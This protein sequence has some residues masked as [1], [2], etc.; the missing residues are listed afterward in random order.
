MAKGPDFTGFGG[1]GP[2][3][4]NDKPAIGGDPSPHYGDGYANRAPAGSHIEAGSDYWIDCLVYPERVYAMSDQQADA[5]DH[6]SRF[7]KVTVGNVTGKKPG[8]ED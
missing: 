8:P 3:P 2:W 7:F 1:Y 5:L 6:N 4:D